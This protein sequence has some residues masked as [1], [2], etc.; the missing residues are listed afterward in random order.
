MYAVY[1][2]YMLKFIHTKIN[3]LICVQAS[4]EKNVF[5]IT[6]PAYILGK[7]GSALNEQPD[8]RAVILG[9]YILENRTTVRAA[10]KP[11]GVSKSTVH[12]DVSCRLCSEDPQLYE[13][14]RNILDINKQERHI[15]GGMATKRKYELISAIKNH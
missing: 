12:K 5:F 7:G 13:K 4:S 3:Q 10:A 11:F 1:D 6:F 15:R 2:W 8:K 14:I 9:Q